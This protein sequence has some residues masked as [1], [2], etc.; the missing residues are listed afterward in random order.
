MKMMM[1]ENDKPNDKQ[2]E[3]GQKHK[4]K[5]IHQENENPLLKNVNFI[6]I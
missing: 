6:P 5:F 2:R 1:N 4:E 3:F